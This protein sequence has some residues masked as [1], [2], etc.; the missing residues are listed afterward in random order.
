MV[1]TEAYGTNGWPSTCSVCIRAGDIKSATWSRP[2]FFLE[3]SKGVF[4]LEVVM[5]LHYDGD[6]LFPRGRIGVIT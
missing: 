6:V 1:R 4:Y 2:L 5:Y 3:E